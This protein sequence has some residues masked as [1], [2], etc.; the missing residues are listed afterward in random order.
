MTGAMKTVANLSQ[1][2]HEHHQRTAETPLFNPVFQLSLDL[3]RLIEA[4]ELTLADCARMIDELE[5]TALSHRAARLRALVQPVGEQANAA[6]LRACFS[7]SDF[8]AFAARW[9]RPQLHAVFTAHP[10]FL[11]TPAQTDAVAEA[12]ASGDPVDQACLA[13][14][15]PALTLAHEHTQAMR[16]IA[17]A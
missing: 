1:R 8:A 15:R 12:A 14:Q 17:N 3:S 2:L 16:A 7:D 4:G 5:C 13:G 11:L 10:T 6:A 9:Q